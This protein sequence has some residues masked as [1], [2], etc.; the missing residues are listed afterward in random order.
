MGCEP[1]GKIVQQLLFGQIVNAAV[2]IGSDR[3]HGAR[4]GCDG[5][6]RQTLEPKMLEM[7]LVVALELLVA[8]N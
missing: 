4:V 2:K 8:G 1:I 7:R 3:P 6:R 5:L